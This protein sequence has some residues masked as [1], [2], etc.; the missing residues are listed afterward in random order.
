MSDFSVHQSMADFQGVKN[1][2][3]KVKHSPSHEKLVK[4]AKE[5]EG[6]FNDI[7]MKSMRS[8]VQKSDLF[9]DSEKVDF[10]QSMLDSEYSKL[11]TSKQSSGLAAAIVRQLEPRLAAEEKAA[12]IAKA[13]AGSSGGASSSSDSHLKIEGGQKP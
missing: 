11:S 13:K 9:G 8:T 5:F 3:E 10:F 12:E 2:A 7:V 6:V 4:A 1:L